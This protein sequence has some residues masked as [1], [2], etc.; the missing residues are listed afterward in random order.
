MK[1][2]AILSNL[3]TNKTLLTIIFV[4]SL[5]NIVGYLIYGNYDIVVYFILISIILIQFSKN[6]IIIL[7]IPLIVVNS[8]VLGKFKIKE[9]LETQTKNAKDAK[10]TPSTSDSTQPAIITPQHMEDVQTQHVDPKSSAEEPDNFEVGRN[11][12]KS[13]YNIDYAST[14]EDAYDELNNIL[15]SDGIKNLT[16][17]TQNLMKQ[18]KQLTEAM[19]QIQP[20]MNNVGPLLEQAQTMMSSMKNSGG[21]DQLNQLAKKFSPS[22]VTNK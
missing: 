11:K 15:G 13:K 16:A 14:I 5:T 2:Q 19:S 20:L 1:P 6:M 12:N 4:L 10:S 18:Q 17:D 8:Y 21:V 9:G 22:N 7:G 3:L